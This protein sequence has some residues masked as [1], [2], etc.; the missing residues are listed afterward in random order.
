MYIPFMMDNHISN[1]RQTW[2]EL[3]K[4]YS[5]KNNMKN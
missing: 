4:N 3:Y 5:L 2:K 1:Y